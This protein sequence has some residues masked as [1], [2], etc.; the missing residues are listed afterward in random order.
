MAVFTPAP[1]KGTS[2]A[3]ASQPVVSSRRQMWRSRL[4]RLDV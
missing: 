4:Y 2:A 1:V 3:P